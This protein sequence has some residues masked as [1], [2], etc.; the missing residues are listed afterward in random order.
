MFATLFIKCA[1]V[2]LNDDRIIAFFILKDKKRELYTNAPR[3]R[4]GVH[5]F[6]NIYK[7]G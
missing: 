7:V 1:K 4:I 3:K 5:N 6:I 2:H